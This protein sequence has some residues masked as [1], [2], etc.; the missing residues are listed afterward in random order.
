MLTITQDIV[1]GL[2]H[3]KTLGFECAHDT[4][5]HLPVDAR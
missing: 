4:F 5:A 1:R 3:V 2:V